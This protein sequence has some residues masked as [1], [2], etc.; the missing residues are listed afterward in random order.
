MARWTSHELIPFLEFTICH[1]AMSH[2]SRPI[3]ES[4]I[5]VPVFRVNWGASCFSRQCQRLYF[6]R[7]MILAEPQRG[8]VT[9]SGQRRAI[10]YSRQ[11][12]N[13][14][15]ERDMHIGLS[16]I[17]RQE[18]LCAIPS[19]TCRYSFVVY[20][21]NRRWRIIVS[22]LSMVDDANLPAAFRRRTAPAAHIAADINHQP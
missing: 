12:R 19:A 15:G 9:P 17:G 20:A 14:G 22:A 8:Q 4:S 6:S 13:Y 18:R 5:T 10:K 1:M 2:L 16:S 11:V 3:G 21:Q 7:K